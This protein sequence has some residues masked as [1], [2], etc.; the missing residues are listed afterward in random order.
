M[1]DLLWRVFLVCCLVGFTS[2]GCEKPP[3]DGRT[4]YLTVGCARCHGSAGEGES[5]GPPLEELSTKFTPETMTAF[6]D[7]PIAFA[8]K[9][10]RLQKWREEYYTPMPKLQMSDEQRAALVVYLFQAHP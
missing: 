6:L 2:L 1:C 9:D 3:V 10:Q 5:L 4:V 7:N 8:E